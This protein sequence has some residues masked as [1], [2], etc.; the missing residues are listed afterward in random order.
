MSGERDT[1]IQPVQ[2]DEAARKAQK[3]RNLWLALAL[4]A[5]VVLVVITTV[6]KLS[7]GAVPER[8]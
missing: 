8:M 6:I 2:L 3:R 7:G 4:V 1:E 5:F